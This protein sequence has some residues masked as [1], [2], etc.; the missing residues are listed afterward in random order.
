MTIGSP[1]ASASGPSVA[2]TKAICLPSGDHASRSPDEGSG[3]FVPRTS[4]RN[5]GDE[6]S[7]FA[8]MTP[9]F[10]PSRPEYASHEPSGDHTG[11]DAVSPPM[12]QDFFVESSIIHSRE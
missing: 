1:L 7:G 9:D 2:E 11:A 5:V 8:I 3:W 4:A 10:S 12:R 6:P